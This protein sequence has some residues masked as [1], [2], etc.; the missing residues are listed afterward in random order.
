MRD[1]R[2]SNLGVYL[3]V[4]LAAVLSWPSLAAA[5]LVPLG[6]A[7]ALSPRPR[8][9]SPE[10]GVRVSIWRGARSAHGSL[11]A[12][13]CSRLAQVTR[14]L[15]SDPTAAAELSV[16]TQ[17]LVGTDAQWRGPLELRGP[18]LLSEAR[19]RVA[20]GHA[21]EA[22][23]SFHGAAKRTPVSEWDPGALR[24]YA[25]SA[26]AA[27]SYVEAVGVYRRLVAVSAW[28]DQHART[29]VRLEAAFAVL[30]LERPEV[31]EALG[32]LAGLDASDVD[33]GATRL[34]QLIEA[35]AQAMTGVATTEVPLTFGAD[36]KSARLIDV[37][38]RL[39]D[40][41]QAWQQARDPEVWSWTRETTVP[42]SY[43]ALGD[44]C[45]SGGK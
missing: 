41:W 14:L 27:G 42:A 35:L 31:S 23:E 45:V 16:A 18:W 43:R 37:D 33:A 9:C 5:E 6:T 1:T 38:W 12:E 21:A 3:V 22:L 39:L 32:Y 40:S 28:L 34:A 36:R 24:D 15:V 19:V 13:V 44:K 10:S 25:T 11:T 17:K 30:R 7:A 26:V 8:A 4:M 20:N 2:R 29:W